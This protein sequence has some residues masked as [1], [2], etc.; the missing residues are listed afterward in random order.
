VKLRIPLGA[1][2]GMN[3]NQGGAP[4]ISRLVFSLAGIIRFRVLSRLENLR[5]V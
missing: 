4:E 2:A 5:A 3:F 1:K